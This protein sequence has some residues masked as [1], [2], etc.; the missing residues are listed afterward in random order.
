M[1]VVIAEKS[2][3]LKK[4]FEIDEDDPDNDDFIDAYMTIVLD[5]HTSGITFIEE[6][7]TIGCNDVPFV[8]VNFSNVHIGK[9]QI[10]TE[11]IDDRKIS[12]KLLTSSRLQAATLNMVQARNILNH[13]IK[14][15]I[16]TECDS[17]K[18]R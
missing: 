17:E 6:D 7:K 5:P 15:T 18:L 4:E 3:E 9:D 14:F 8:T 12:Q 13:L 16:C 10:L 1:L 11:G 2:D